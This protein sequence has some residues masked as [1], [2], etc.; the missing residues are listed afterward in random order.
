MMG[1]KREEKDG[2][3]RE[4]TK[5]VLPC[6]KGGF[7]REAVWT[8]EKRESPESDRKSLTTKGQKRTISIATRGSRDTLAG[9]PRGERGNPDNFGSVKGKDARKR[10]ISARKG[11]GK[12]WSLESGEPGSSSLIVEDVKKMVGAKG[13]EPST[14]PTPRECATGLRHAP[15]KKKRNS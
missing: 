14:T 4:G 13:F 9:S 2:A 7:P 8:P 6:I 15:T 1:G 11:P 12:S 10:E 5:E 3:K